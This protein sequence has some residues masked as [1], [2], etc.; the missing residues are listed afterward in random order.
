[1]K[2]NYK[3]PAELVYNAL[4]EYAKENPDKD[5]INLGYWW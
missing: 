3:I 5:D 4:K 1:L 2:K